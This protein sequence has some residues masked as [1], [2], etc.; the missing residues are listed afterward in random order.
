MVDRLLTA[1]VLTIRYIEG[2]DAIARR[3]EERDMLPR[4][5]IGDRIRF[6]AVQVD[7]ENGGV[8]VFI[9]MVERPDRFQRPRDRPDDACASLLED[10]AERK[11]NQVVI[12]NHHDPFPF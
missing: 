3:K 4:E 9:A 1:W 6:L 5:R 11:R 8:N 10:G 2:V 12:F 7:I